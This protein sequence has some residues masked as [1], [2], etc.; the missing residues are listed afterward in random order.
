M[1][2]R[3]ETSNAIIQALID[4]QDAG[5]GDKTINTALSHLQSDR[6]LSRQLQD[7]WDAHQYNDRAVTFAM[8]RENPAI[9]RLTDAAVKMLWFL[10]TTANQSGCIQVSVPVLSRI[11]G[12]KRTKANAAMRELE[13]AG[14]ITVIKPPTRH[15][16]P[17]YMVNPEVS[18]KGK[19]GKQKEYQFREASDRSLRL[20]LD[21]EVLTEIVSV[22]ED[23]A[24]GTR[25]FKFTRVSLGDK[26]EPAGEATPTSSTE[27][28]KA[29]KSFRRHHKAASGEPSSI[30]GQ[31]SFSDFY[32]DGELPF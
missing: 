12:C 21:V 28:E 16:A 9:M 18:L 29:V 15:D 24:T 25:A 17:V 23:P 8:V 5:Q 27:A 22:K 30:P 14:V 31:M 3:N 13:N 11:C 1:S 4:L 20:S 32:K 26:K 7:K 6:Q 10:A 19:H 2:K